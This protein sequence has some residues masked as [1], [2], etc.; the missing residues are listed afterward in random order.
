MELEYIGNTKEFMKNICLI[1]AR[2]VQKEFKK[3]IK[4]F[5]GKPLIYWSIITAKSSNLFDEIYVST[6]DSEKL[7][8]QK[9][10]ER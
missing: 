9:N 7:K 10:M 8:L 6:D 5:H 4:I 2:E 3:N 1:P